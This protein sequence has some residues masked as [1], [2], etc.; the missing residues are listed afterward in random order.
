[1]K[2]LIIQARTSSER[3]PKKVLKKLCK[4]TLLEHIIERAKEIGG[5]QSIVLAIPDKEEDKVL[6]EFARREGIQ[7]FFGPEDDVLT[8]FIKAA[9]SVQASYILRICADS[10]LF[11][12]E[13][14]KKVLKELEAEEADF[15]YTTGLPLGANTGAVSLSALKKENALLTK[16]SPHRE[17]VTSFIVRNPSLFRI[18][19]MEAPQHLCR[20]H[21]RLTV[22]TEEDLRLLRIIYSRLY[23]GAPIPLQEAI[24]LLDSEPH[25]LKINEGVRQKEVPR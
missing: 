6:A 19:K 17:H 25:L 24:R 16:D 22:D 2:T 23:E 18:K 1:M 9:E 5:V 10:P 15:V 4:K 3:L 20:P 13:S 8:R 14:A 12:I 11:D 21:Y 7:Y